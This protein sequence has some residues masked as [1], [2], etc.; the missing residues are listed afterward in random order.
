MPEPDPANV[1]PGDPP[2]HPIVNITGERVALGPA[3]RDLIPL[4]QRWINDFEVQR[5]IGQLS[6]P[7]SLD[8]ETVWYD[9]MVKSAPSFFTIY[10]LPSVQPI[11]STDLHDMDVRNGTAEFGILIGEADAR[12]KGIGTEVTRLM[13]DYAFSVLGLNNVMLRVHA[14]NAGAIRAYEK[15]GFREVGRRRSATAMGG[16]RWDL[17]FMDCVP[18][19][20]GG[21]SVFPAFLAPRPPDDDMEMA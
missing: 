10:E 21:Q 1:A 5:N 16:R 15:A 17:I 7:F 8:A 20:L 18:S 11:G 3:R 9:D 14:Y 6:M 19:D 13:A 4:Y 2:E 12:G